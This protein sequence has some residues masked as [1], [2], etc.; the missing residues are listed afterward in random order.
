MSEEEFLEALKI[1]KSLAKVL[2]SST[3]TLTTEVNGKSGWEEG[4]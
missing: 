3:D 2:K 1:K 4:K